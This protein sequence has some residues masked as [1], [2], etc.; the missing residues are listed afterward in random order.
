M[1]TIYPAGFLRFVSVADN[2]VTPHRVWVRGLAIGG[3]RLTLEVDKHTSEILRSG[4]RGT[5]LA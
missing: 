1:R 2:S 3:R 5:L 4:N